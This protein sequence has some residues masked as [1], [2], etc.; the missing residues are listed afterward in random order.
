MILSCELHSTSIKY[1]I[2]LESDDSVQGIGQGK[3][4]IELLHNTFCFDFPFEITE[5]HPDL[6]ALSALTVVLPWIGSSI[7]FPHPG[8]VRLHSGTDQPPACLSRCIRLY[9]WS[10]L[11][12]I[13]T[14]MRGRPTKKK[15]LSA[16]VG[17]TGAN[18][19]VLTVN[20]DD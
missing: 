11:G 6:I 16:W 2:E 7:T 13:L 15:M 1:T 9:H 3:K 10:V 12:S 5:P 18:S 20:S 4:L 19:F 14:S 8:R 17:A